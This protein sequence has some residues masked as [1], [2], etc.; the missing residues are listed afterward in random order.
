M[1]KSII[2]GRGTGKTKKLMIM[3]K[4]NNGVLVC[5]NPLAM[6]SK[7]EAY[8][9]VGFDIISYEDYLNINYDSERKA[10]LTNLKCL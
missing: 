1:F 6:R 7:A 8:G 5:S 10:I 3:A 4:E 9:I 2:E